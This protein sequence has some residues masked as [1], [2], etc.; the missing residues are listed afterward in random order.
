MTGAQSSYLLVSHLLKALS[1]KI[2]TPLSVISNDLHFISSTYPQAD[3]GR[4]RE[5]VD[6]IAEILSESIRLLSKPS[7]IETFDIAE[8]FKDIGVKSEVSERIRSDKLLLGQALSTLKT[9][10]PYTVQG[11]AQF[12]ALTTVELQGN[13]TAPEGFEFSLFTQLFN[14]LLQHQTTLPPIID[15]LFDA[16]RVA[17]HGTV[18]GEVVTVQL[19]FST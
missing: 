5:K 3:S 11:S 6:D 12:G 1:H 16:S 13:L 15:A 10:F 19:Q 7:I 4:A 2:R 8:I 17:V 14:E 18:A 9:P